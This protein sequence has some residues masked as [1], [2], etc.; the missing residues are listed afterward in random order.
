MQA[1]TASTLL[2]LTDHP[3]PE[4]IFLSYVSSSASSKLEAK[5]HLSFVERSARPAEFFNDIAVSEDGTYAVV[6]VYTGK[7]KVIVFD[8]GEYHADFDVT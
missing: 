4:L 5:K 6:S 7:L 1:T 3:D 2:L 8:R